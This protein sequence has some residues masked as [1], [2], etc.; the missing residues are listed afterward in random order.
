MQTWRILPGDVRA[1]L[2]TVPDG[3][4]QTCITSPPYWG[5]RDYGHAGQLG[6]EPTPGGPRAVG[7]MVSPPWRD[8]GLRLRFHPRKPGRVIGQG[9]SPCGPERG[10]FGTRF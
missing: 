7:G 5:L 6:L 8:G 9:E 10:S 3:S 2:A 4:V 1:S